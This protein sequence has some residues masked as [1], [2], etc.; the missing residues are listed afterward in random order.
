MSLE[1]YNLIL[2]QL[3]LLTHVALLA[4][5]VYFLFFKNCKFSKE[6]AKS[7]ELIILIFSSAAV[8]GSL[9]YSEVVGFNPCKLCWTQRIF[10][11]PILI[12]VIVSLISKE[13]LK[14]KFYLSLAI[15]GF[16]VSFYH[17]F[18]Q[19]T[20]RTLE[21]GV[22]GQSANC[23]EIWVKMF[24]Y[25]TIPVMAGTGF[26]MIILACLYKIFRD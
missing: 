7:Y 17:S 20:G 3:V 16:L 13:N 12:L 21:C 23:G 1:L 2:G 14:P 18:S 9:I 8:I 6:I 10:M 22:I 4:G 15:P 26:A 24:G 25:I 5:I 11:F 19:L